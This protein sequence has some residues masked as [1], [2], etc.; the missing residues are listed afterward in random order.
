MKTSTVLLGFKIL[1]HQHF[2]EVSFTWVKKNNPANLSSLRFH[3]TSTFQKMYFNQ[4][5][6]SSQV[7]GTYYLPPAPLVQ[8]YIYRQ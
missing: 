5:G 1:P 8:P 4:A 6:A 3:S 7:K 2:Q